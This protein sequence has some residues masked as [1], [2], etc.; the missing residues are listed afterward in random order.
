MDYFNI[1]GYDYYYF[2][3]I[4]NNMVSYFIVKPYVIIIDKAFNYI[5]LLTLVFMN[6]PTKD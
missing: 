2:I 5:G 6:H 4:N 3:Q 1:R